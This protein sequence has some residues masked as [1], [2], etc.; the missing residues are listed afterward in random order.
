MVPY[1]ETTNQSAEQ[2]MRA[3]VGLD[4]AICTDVILLR[5]DPTGREDPFAL[6]SLVNRQRWEPHTIKSHTT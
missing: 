2:C 5:T 1:L 3:N 6:V 4:R